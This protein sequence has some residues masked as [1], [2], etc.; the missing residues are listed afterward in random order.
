MT[1]CQKT[2]AL[3]NAVSSTLHVVWSLPVSVRG[4]LAG[5][6]PLE[7]ELEAQGLTDLRRR[8]AVR[9]ASLSLRLRGESC[10]SIRNRTRRGKRD[11]NDQA[12]V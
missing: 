9:D 4:V 7:L 2:L 6:P 11:K 10:G 1:F 5:L 8:A 12:P 3:A